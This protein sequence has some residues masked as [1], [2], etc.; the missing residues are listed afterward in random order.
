MTT[1]QR[2]LRG[3]NVLNRYSG[4]TDIEI[5]QRDPDLRTKYV[6]IPLPATLKM[7][8]KD[9]DALLKAGWRHEAPNWIFEP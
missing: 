8:A 2:L 9:V 6:A 3:L 7:D 1:F 5:E 4:I